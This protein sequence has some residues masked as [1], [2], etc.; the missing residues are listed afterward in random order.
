MGQTEHFRH[1]PEMAF[2]AGHIY[3]NM[4][5]DNRYHLYIN[6]KICYKLQ[7]MLCYTYIS[8]FHYNYSS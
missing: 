1:L 3:G 2:P 4:F 5:V 7:D 8:L 6:Y